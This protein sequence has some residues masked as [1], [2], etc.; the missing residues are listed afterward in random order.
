MKSEDLF[1]FSWR[2]LWIV[3][4]AGFVSILLHNFIGALFGFEEAFFFIIVIFVI[5]IYILIMAVYSIVYLVK[6]RK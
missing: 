5:P 3:V 2:K 1:L 4:V 6:K